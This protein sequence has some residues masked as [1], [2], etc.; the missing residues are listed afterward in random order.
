MSFNF[1]PEIDR[2]SYVYARWKHPLLWLLP[3]HT[4]SDQGF[5]IH[6]KR[7]RGKIWIWKFERPPGGEGKS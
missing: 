1:F 4:C 7:F 5:V 3:N 2:K 6:Y